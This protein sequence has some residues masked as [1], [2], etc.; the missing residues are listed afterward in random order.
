MKDFLKKLTK[1]L[2]NYKITARLMALVGLVAIVTDVLLFIFYQFSGGMQEVSG[3]PT[4]VTAFDGNKILGMVYFLSAIIAI[5]LGI[6]IVYSSFPYCFP[7]D[8]MNP[9]KALPWMCVANAVFHL[10]LAVLV[11]VLLATEVSQVMIGFVI[12]LVLSFLVALCSA[13]FAFPALQCRF[14]MPS[15]LEE[16]KA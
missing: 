11:I 1:T 3:V 9:N 7:K 16:K 14:Y 4:Q 13:F 10:V 6:A 15:L 12:A 5:I 8:K 2:N